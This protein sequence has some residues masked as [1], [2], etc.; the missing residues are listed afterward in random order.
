MTSGSPYPA[1]TSASAPAPR[2]GITSPGSGKASFGQGSA[3]GTGMKWAALQDAA[4]AVAMLAG[5]QPE[6]STPEIRA[7][8]AAIRDAGGYRLELAECAIGDL[9]AVMES[10]LS[11]LLSARARG[12]A[13]TL[14]AQTLWQDFTDARAAILALVPPHGSLGHRRLA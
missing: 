7:F 1:S 3:T 5:L 14:A 13:A 12:A 10:G 11:A 9:S 2:A 8:P 4:G 6:P